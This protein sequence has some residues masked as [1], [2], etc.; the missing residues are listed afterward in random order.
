MI[1]HRWVAETLLEIHKYCLL[2]NLPK[3]THALDL[4]TKAAQNEILLPI[5]SEILASASSNLLP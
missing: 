5:N 1:E 4:A 3:V 2:N